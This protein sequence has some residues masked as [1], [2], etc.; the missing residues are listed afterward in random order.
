MDENAKKY[1]KG[2][3]VCRVIHCI[4]CAACVGAAVAGF[5]AMLAVGNPG[6]G[7]VT[8]A[9][10]GGMAALEGWMARSVSGLIREYQKLV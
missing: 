6:S 2:C 9:L 5:I 4:S 10:S 7:I 8:V 1:I 3:K